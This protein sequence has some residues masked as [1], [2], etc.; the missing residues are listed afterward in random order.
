ML[1]YRTAS[2]TFACVT[3]IN[4]FYD[5]FFDFAVFFNLPF[6]FETIYSSLLVLWGLSERSK[7]EW[8]NGNDLSFALI[9]CNKPLTLLP[10]IAALCFYAKHVAG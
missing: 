4:I 7:A 2:H 8:S 9:N 10:C 3:L 5:I 6:L 1:T